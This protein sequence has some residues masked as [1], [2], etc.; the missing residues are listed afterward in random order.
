MEVGGTASFRLDDERSDLLSVMCVEALMEAAVDEDDALCA[1]D[2][3]T[4][5]ARLDAGSGRIVRC[6]IVH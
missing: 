3:S 5:S 4:A 6:T 2:G 1:V